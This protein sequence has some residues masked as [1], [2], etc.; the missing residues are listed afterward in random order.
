MKRMLMVASVV[1]MI[2]SFNRDNIRLLQEMGY[3]VHVATN[4][5]WGSMYSNEKIENIRRDLTRQ[6]VTLFQIDFE[7]DIKKMNGHVRAYQQLKTIM[8]KQRYD[9]IHCH[10]PI[11]GVIG[12]LVSRQTH[13]PCM[14]TAHGFHFFKGSPSLNWMLYYPI[15]R[16]LARFTDTIITINEEDYE[17]A[18][19][20]KT[21]HTYRIPGIGV[22]TK[23]IEAVTIDRQAKRRAL[24]VDTDTDFVLLS[25]GELN[26]NKNHETIIRAIAA[27]QEPTLRYWIAGTGN[28]RAQLEHLI[29]E[30]GL[31][32]QVQLLGYRDDVIEVMKAADCFVFPSKREGLGMAALE[33]MAAG[34]PLITSNVHGINDY[35]I[36]GVTG[37]KRAPIDI[38]GFAKAIRTM[39]RDFDLSH[40]MGL[41]NSEVVKAFDVNRSK[42]EMR[43][44]YSEFGQFKAT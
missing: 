28:Y 9:F 10:S 15:E 19:S 27:L 37:Y 20:F 1:S 22:D 16:T 7:R 36:E 8:T 26:E 3:D 18:Q 14:Y 34:L 5:E 30:L 40:Q 23:R 4:F 39:Q 11:G 41:H 44:I 25:V 17:R 29:R 42:E 33:A 21:S 35:S 13:T 31:S 24:G 32:G 38:L 6:G 43:R 12:R 2:E